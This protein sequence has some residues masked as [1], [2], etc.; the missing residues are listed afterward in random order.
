METVRKIVREEL[1]LYDEYIK[2][3][4]EVKLQQKQMWKAVYNQSDNFYQ[5]E[6]L[7]K[8]MKKNAE[9]TYNM[10]SGWHDDAVKKLKEFK[11]KNKYD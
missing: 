1:I 2:L 7:N 10:Y 9:F 6:E 11:E 5:D 8:M 3:K 4:A